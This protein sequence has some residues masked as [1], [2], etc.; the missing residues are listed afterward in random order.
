MEVFHILNCTG[1]AVP[2]IL[3]KRSDKR[4]NHYYEKLAFLRQNPLLLWMMSVKDRANKKFVLTAVQHQQYGRD[5]D[6]VLRFANEILR[7][8]KAFIKE[9]IK[10]SNLSLCENFRFLPNRPD[11]ELDTIF[12][13][14]VHKNKVKRKKV[15]ELLGCRNVT[16]KSLAIAGL[17]ED[18]AF[19]RRINRYTFQSNDDLMEL[20]LERY[21]VENRNTPYSYRKKLHPLQFASKRQLL[22]EKIIQ[23]A[24]EGNFKKWLECAWLK[25]K[26]KYDSDKTF[27]LLKR[28]VANDPMAICLREEFDFSLTRT[29][30]R[31]LVLYACSIPLRWP[32]LHTILLYL[33]EFQ[34]DTEVV[35]AALRQY[36]MNILHCETDFK[37]NNLDTIRDALYQYFNKFAH[38][39]PSFKL[40]AFPAALRDDKWV[41]MKAI[42][43]CPKNY[44]H[45]SGRLRKDRDVVLLATKTLKQ[46]S[47]MDEFAK[48]LYE[49][50]PLYE[51]LLY[52]FKKDLQLIVECGTLIFASDEIRLAKKIVSRMI[53]VHK[54]GRI[55][56]EADKSLWN[57]EGLLFQALCTEHN[58]LVLIGIKKI[59]PKGSVEE[60]Q[61]MLEQDPLLLPMMS[62]EDRAN[63]ELVL[64]A[65]EHQR[66]GLS[67]L[68]C[69]NE[70]LR[71]DKEFVKKVL[72]R[73]QVPSSSFDFVSYRLRNDKELVPTLL[74]AKLLVFDDLPFQWMKDEW[75]IENSVSIDFRAYGRLAYYFR[76]K[77]S[78]LLKALEAP[79]PLK[80][81]CRSIPISAAP[82][83]LRKDHEVI[84]AALKQTWQ[85][86]QYICKD[87]FLSDRALMDKVLEG[88][89]V[90]SEER[91][92]PRLYK[93]VNPLSNIHETLVSDPT[94]LNKF[95]EYNGLSLSWLIPPIRT[96]FTH[97][98]RLKTVKRAIKNNPC[99]I[100]ALYDDGKK[101]LTSLE[102]YPDER[103]LVLYTCSIP[104]RKFFRFKILE[105][106]VDF[107][108]DTEVVR[109]ALR[110]NP[111]NLRY[112]SQNFMENNLP[113]I[114]K[115]LLQ[116]FDESLANNSLP[117]AS[118]DEMDKLVFRFAPESCRG[119]KALSM[120]AIRVHPYNYYF[121]SKNLQRDPCVV[122]YMFNNSTTVYLDDVLPKNLKRKPKKFKSMSHYE[123]RLFSYDEKL[124]DLGA[125]QLNAAKKKNKKEEVF[126]RPTFLHTYK[127]Y[128]KNIFSFFE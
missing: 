51:V 46:R 14:Q 75:V 121:L 73:S 29:Q 39:K 82:H 128:R 103:D 44:E 100:T 120:K 43:R 50:K 88:Y 36:P 99:A 30:V 9:V 38:N 78:L 115:A 71:D 61:K 64:T 66:D 112:V 23:K 59:V 91:L 25:Y 95:I 19:V 126:F 3:L 41:A 117:E 69:A 94:L 21:N 48:V 74:R 12:N 116:Y 127:K 125:E 52:F 83:A 122:S 31:K 81:D 86:I 24:T 34:N 63:P 17:K 28:A 13:D 57:D 119:D 16:D 33:K 93:V 22:D 90:E 107:R 54:N 42:K 101:G 109:A 40:G 70:L 6:S 110:Q 68:W 114:R 20:A 15:D 97:R 118:R 87:S 123:S 37:D 92:N 85:S 55:L 67:V 77:K 47:S 7:E 8:D 65:V 56:V 105:F 124:C 106:S 27:K 96:V 1:F 79:L 53:H 89:K 49:F 62:T 10:C 18:W 4:D 11:E 32:N 111:S 76:K 104:L 45:V 5:D 84:L 72:Q 102:L 2:T 113:T 80:F 35:E 108:D 58:P 26:Y 60:K 98:E